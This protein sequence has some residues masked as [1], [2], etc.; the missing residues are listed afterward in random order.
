[1]PC[2]APELRLVRDVGQGPEGRVRKAETAR[3]PRRSGPDAGD[4]RDLVPGGG[5]AL[6]EGVV[7]GPDGADVVTRADHV[8][9][10][11]ALVER[12]EEAAERVVE[13]IDVVEQP[14]DV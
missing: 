10:E 4:G 11:P 7:E 8:Q 2:A 12:D 14:E 5:E 1:E 9:R 13:G 3:L 6:Q